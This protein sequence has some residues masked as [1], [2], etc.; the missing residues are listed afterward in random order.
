MQFVQFLEYF[1]IMAILFHQKNKYH[2]RWIYFYEDLADSYI[3]DDFLDIPLNLFI[4]IIYQAEKS[5]FCELAT[6][7]RLNPGLT[8]MVGE[9]RRNQPPLPEPQRFEN[10]FPQHPHH[11][12]HSSKHC[13]HRCHHNG[14]VRIRIHVR[15]TLI[16]R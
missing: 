13:E 2:T 1:K 16:V 12:Q 7:P 5:L 15:K 4:S 6:S 14:H 8:E 10:Q 11:K 9:F 3:T